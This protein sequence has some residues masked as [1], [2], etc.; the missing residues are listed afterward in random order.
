MKRVGS[1]RW[2]KPLT[3]ALTI[4]GFV[5]GVWVASILFAANSAGCDHM[6][7][8]L[9]LLP[10]GL[11]C[12]G[13]KDGVRHIPWS[14]ADSSPIYLVPIVVGGGGIG[15]LIVGLIGSRLARRAAPRS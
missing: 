10:P 11:R 3:V 5:I 13:V 12:F 8:S 4:I 15:A 1:D 7:R 9:T 6:E 2:G 14:S